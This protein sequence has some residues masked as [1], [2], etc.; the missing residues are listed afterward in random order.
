MCYIRVIEEFDMTH[1]SQVRIV[2]HQCETH[3]GAWGMRYGW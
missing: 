3:W 2:V 1:T